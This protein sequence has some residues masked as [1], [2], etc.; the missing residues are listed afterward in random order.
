MYVT[1]EN[2]RTDRKEAQKKPD[3]KLLLF[4]GKPGV[5]LTNT[6]VLRGKYRKWKLKISWNSNKTLNK[7]PRMPCFSYQYTN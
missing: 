4:D 5:S 6:V 2:G 3:K 7:H 1:T